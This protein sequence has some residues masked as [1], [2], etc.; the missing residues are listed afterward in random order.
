MSLQAE[1]AAKPPAATKPSRW[2]RWAVEALI[3]IAAVTAFQLWQAR[4]AP[5]G[6]AP[7]FAGQLLD[8]QPFELNAW[9]E[10]H[11]GK[12]TLLYF[13]AEWCPVCKTTA[14]NVSAIAED[15]PVTSIAIQS[16]PAEAITKVMQARDYRWPTLPDQTGE[17]L[18]R[19][20]L[21]GTPAF[22]VINPAGNIAFV[23]IGYTSEIGLRLRLWWA[24][25]QS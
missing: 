7:I 21:P 20:G 12:A 13:W 1:P 8:G 4:N 3:F 9:C 18:K 24:S 14:G 25:K 22:I 16:G 2:R 10:S 17:I 11:P 15:W 6:Q 19:Y 23:S 5:Q